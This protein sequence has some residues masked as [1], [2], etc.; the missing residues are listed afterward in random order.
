[1]EKFILTSKKDGEL[2][3]IHLPVAKHY[4]PLI[5]EPDQPVP[6]NSSN[7]SYPNEMEELNSKWK[8]IAFKHDSM[9][10]G[11]QWFNQPILQHHYS[12]H[13]YPIAQGPAIPPL[14]KAYSNSQGEKSYQEVFADRTEFNH[15][16]QECFEWTPNKIG[17]NILEKVVKTKNDKEN[18][19]QSSFEI[20]KVP[21]NN[22]KGD[23][24]LKDMS[25]VYTC[26]FLN[27]IIHCPCTVCKI[28]KGDCKSS[29]KENPCEDCNSQC[30]QH[31]IVGLARLFEFDKDQFTIITD[32]LRLFRHAIP[33]PGIPISCEICTKDVME[34]QILHH[35]FHMR[36]KFCRLEAR[37]YDIL[38]D[39]SLKDYK[40]AVYHYQNKENRTCSFCFLM[41]QD[42]YQRKKH[43]KRMH[44][45][46]ESDYKCK[47][48][49]KT[50]SNK[51]ALTYHMEKHKKEL[52]KFCCDECGKQY[53][54]KQG[55]KTHKIAV[56]ESDA[57]LQLPCDHCDA[58]FTNKSNLNRHK[59]SVHE[60]LMNIN[61]D[62]IP[63][64]K[65]L[66]KFQCSNCDK[67][68]SRKDILKRH[69]QSVHSEIQTFSCEYCSSKFQRSDVL[70]RHIKSLHN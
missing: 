70:A 68:F 13:S 22:I 25:I 46:L 61:A 21:N 58:L 31:E 50:Y 40:K 60:D 54:S 4:E 51:N 43:E 52:V 32:S 53:R 34:H 20:R 47:T 15:I 12:K 38:I 63:P 9:F 39:G 16:S 45:K 17:L 56:H 11:H 59:R 35:V 44:S 57:P 6:S 23:T 64:L 29:C 69:I 8:N 19:I 49:G 7:E 2:F 30:T 66:H 36:C 3:N 42:S 14:D 37:P 55:L 27:C 65:E 41:L 1:M 48:C 67:E 26:N 5:D 33:Y 62:Y 18:E 28:I 24:S 10:K